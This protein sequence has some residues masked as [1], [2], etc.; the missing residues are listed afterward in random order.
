M[1]EIKKIAERAGISPRQIDYWIRQGFVDVEDK[2]VGTG[3]HRVI[4]VTEA[5][6]FYVLGQLL[7]LG[8]TLDKARELMPALLAQGFTDDDTI[9]VTFS[10]KRKAQQ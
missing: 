6:Q 2:N 8:F 1:P 3:F 4:T 5:K 7:A 10:F 9:A